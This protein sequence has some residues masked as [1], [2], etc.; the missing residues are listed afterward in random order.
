MLDQRAV[1]DDVN[2][3]RHRQS[4]SNLALVLD[5]IWASGDTPHNT[6]NDVRVPL[7]SCD[8]KHCVRFGGCT[9]PR[10]RALVTCLK[11]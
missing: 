3:L 8:R 4:V 9:R 7:V 2:R 5:C 1:V 11:A 6:D 10:R